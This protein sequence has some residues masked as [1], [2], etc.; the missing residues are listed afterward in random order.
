MTTPPG[1]MR[2]VSNANSLAS[3]AISSPFLWFWI[4][5]ASARRSP[6]CLFDDPRGLFGEIAVSISS[7]YALSVHPL[8]LWAM[9]LKCCAWVLAP[10]AV[11]DRP[12]RHPPSL[13][14]LFSSCHLS[15]LFR[16]P[17]DP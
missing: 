5:E 8:S 1:P 9:D 6:F 14:S 10:E 11:D 12:N 13:S 2:P 3:L 15:E 16:P 7:S 17:Y 4:L